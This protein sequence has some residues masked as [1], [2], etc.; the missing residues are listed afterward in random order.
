MSMNLDFTDVKDGFEAIP[1]G[2]Y[3]VKVVEC[4]KKMNKAQTGEYL[5]FAYEVCDGG[6]QEGARVYDICSLTPKALWKLKAT[7]KA[8]GFDVTGVV[9][10][11]VADTIGLECIAVVTVEQYEGRNV[12]RVKEIRAI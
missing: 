7:L 5:N 3:P 1:A 6:D 2:E 9:D 10:F 12:N 8:L 11:D 4:E